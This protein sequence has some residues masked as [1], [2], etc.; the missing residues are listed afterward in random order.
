M[1]SNRPAISV[2]FDA[3]EAQAALGVIYGMA[4]S[5]KTDRY[6]GSVLKFA[7]EVM[8]KDFDI[9]MDGAVATNPDKYD[10]VFD[11]TD[12]GKVGN[13]LWKHKLK[14]RGASREAT[15]E[16]RASKKAIPTPEQYKQMGD[17]RFS[18][19]PDDELAKLSGR[20]YVFRWKAPIMEYNL[21]VTISPRWSDAL[22]VPTGDASRP[23]IITR[24]QVVVDNP[25]GD[26]TGMFTSFW[27]GWW[28]SAGQKI[29]EEQVKTT[30][31]NDLGK[32]PM[33]TVTRK[34]RKT[35]GK[36]L[37]LTTFSD[38]EYAFESGKEFAQAYVLGKSKSYS[39]ANKYIEENW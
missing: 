19:I 39:S 13:R 3:S 37:K 21:R 34:F 30:V 10:H 14:G 27:T 35:T 18:I 9:A 16:W 33:E 7:H 26:N 8:S 29:F 23:F 32:I 17:K 2:D 5:I 20:R 38:A 11:W 4:T 1:A 36:T 22:F 28:G 25:G 15:F 24:A 6:M 12:N 31:E